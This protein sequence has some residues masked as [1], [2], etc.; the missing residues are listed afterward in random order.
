MMK[1]DKEKKEEEKKEANKSF[2]EKYASGHTQSD[3]GGV[4][5]IAQNAEEQ[6]APDAKSA[7]PHHE[8]QKK[9]IELEQDMITVKEQFMRALAEKE[10]EKKRVIKE[11][12]NKERYAI[13]DFSKD[14]ISC[15]DILFVS[16]NSLDAESLQDKK[17]KGFY[18]GMCMIRNEFMRVCEKH[19][20]F[21]IDPLMEQ[22]D[23][24]LHEVSF[25]VE[26]DAASGTVVQVMKA[27][28]KLHGRLISP[29][30]VSVSAGPKK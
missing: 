23:H 13:M 28:Y 10:N 6:S 30:L 3:N 22:F 24:N 4:K 8:N 18:D 19:G 5:D 27:G 25:T 15:I 20:L 12:E 29:A 21:R 11:A 14:L 2:R 17:L 7:D 26:N 1:K 9:L 16:T